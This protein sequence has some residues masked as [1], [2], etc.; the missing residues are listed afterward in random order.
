M[1]DNFQSKLV[2]HARYFDNHHF[3]IIF[4]INKSLRYDY[5]PPRKYKFPMIILL[6]TRKGSFGFEKL[7]VMNSKYQYLTF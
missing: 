6:L 7:S 5:S 3:A 2:E 4:H 1:V